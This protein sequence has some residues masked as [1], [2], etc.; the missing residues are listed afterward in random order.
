MMTKEENEQKQTEIEL[1][2]DEFQEAM[3]KIPPWILRWGISVLGIIV[4]ILLIGSFLFKS[5]EVITTKVVLTGKIPPASIVAKTSGKIN[6]ILIHNN[7]MVKQGD[8]LAIIDNPANTNDIQYLKAYMHS[9]DIIHFLFKALP[10]STLNVGSL[11]SSYSSFYSAILSYIQFFQQN[12][13]PMKITLLKGRIT[14]NNLLVENNKKQQA[15]IYEQLIIGKKQYKRDSLL[16]AQG[17]LSLEDFEKSYN[18]LLQDKLTYENICNSIENTEM[19]TAQ[20]N[21]SVFDTQMQSTEK[22]TELKRQIYLALNQLKNDLN[23]WETDF[24]LVAPIDGKITFT[25]YWIKNQNITAGENIFTV[26]P[27]SNTNLIGKALLPI[28]RSGKVKIGQP[29]RIKFDNFQDNEYGTVMGVVSCISL[30]PFKNE[31]EN[32]YMVEIALSEG[33]KTT[34]KK[35]LPFMAEMSG[36]A[37]IITDDMNLIERFFMPLRKLWKESIK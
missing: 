8:Y 10:K 21:E 22:E 29:V 2:S 20:I 19:Q 32:N 12:Y 14:K 36:E 37:D 4:V 9:F 3:S 30:T 18:Q 24:V 7:E 28:A 11:Q 33:L 5:P 25:K 31:Q 26:I 15:I 23:V 34:Y 13:Y 35:T 27:T 17:I 6:N 1:R 16:Y